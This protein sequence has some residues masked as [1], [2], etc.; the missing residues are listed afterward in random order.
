MSW[1]T[2]AWILIILN[3]IVWGS[4][5]FIELTHPLTVTTVTC[6]FPKNLTDGF[7]SC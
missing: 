7:W 6:T 2:V 3:V 4:V 5:F 1:Y